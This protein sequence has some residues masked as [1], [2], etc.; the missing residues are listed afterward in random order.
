MTNQ[1]QQEIDKFDNW[2]SM[3]IEL[4]LW[5]VA[6]SLVLPVAGVFLHF[7]WRIFLLGWNL[8]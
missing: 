1:H 4:G 8:A 7:Y 6:A 3:G 2:A 5:L